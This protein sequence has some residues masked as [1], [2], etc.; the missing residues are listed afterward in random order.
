MSGAP[1]TLELHQPGTVGKGFEEDEILGI[2][3]TGEKLKPVP[4]FSP[5]GARHGLD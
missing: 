2:G 5:E 4:I 3:T 1:V